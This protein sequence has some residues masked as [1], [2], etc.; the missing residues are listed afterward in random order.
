MFLEIQPVVIA[1]WY[2]NDDNLNIQSK[3]NKEWEGQKTEIESQSMCIA[4]VYIHRNKPDTQTSCIE[5]TEQQNINEFNKQNN[6]SEILEELN[7]N[8]NQDQSHWCP[9]LQ[10]IIIDM[11]PVTFIDSCGSKMLERVSMHALFVSAQQPAII[12]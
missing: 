5:K 12:L 1:N 6:F 7:I 8:G 9:D 2:V 10:Y 11:A 4:N 3:T